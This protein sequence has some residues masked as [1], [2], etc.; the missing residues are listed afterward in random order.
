MNQQRNRRIGA[1]TSKTRAVI[2]EATERLM[3]DEGYAAVTYRRVAAAAAVTA[4]LVQYYFPTLDSLFLALLHQH[5]EPNLTRL[6]EA[7]DSEDTNPLRVIWEYSADETSSALMVEFMA[8]GNH[9]KGIRSEIAEVTRRSRQA[10]L[11]AISHVRLRSY[12]AA[13]DLPPP[14]LLFL[15][16]A[17][18]KILLMESAMDVS[19]GHPEILDA[20]ERFLDEVDRHPGT[21]QRG[22]TDPSYA[23]HQERVGPGSHRLLAR[24]PRTLVSRT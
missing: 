20:V 1:K 3:I 17:V 18:P 6:T 12:F 14:A 16:A 24:R 7:L 13:Q 10:Q 22:R 15:L 11:D 19:I 5:A 4:P 2:L 9:R 23:G 8:L 21:W